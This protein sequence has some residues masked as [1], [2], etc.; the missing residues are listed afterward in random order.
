MENPMLK[1]N[2][3]GVPAANDPDR[4]EN[5]VDQSTPAKSRATRRFDSRRLKKLMFVILDG[6]RHVIIDRK[7]GGVV[8]RHADKGA[9]VIL[10]AANLRDLQAAGRLKSRTSF[11]GA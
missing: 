5:N 9:I 6:Q 4:V 2:A 3:A 7:F 1:P 10:P 8:L 11:E